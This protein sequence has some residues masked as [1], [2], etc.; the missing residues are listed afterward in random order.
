VEYVIMAALST[1]SFLCGWVTCSVCRNMT[2]VT[3]PY[4]EFD[5]IKEFLKPSHNSAMVPCHVS[6]KSMELSAGVGHWKFCPFC[7]VSMAQHQ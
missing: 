3:G 7:G 4:V 6:K 1:A 5:D 2:T